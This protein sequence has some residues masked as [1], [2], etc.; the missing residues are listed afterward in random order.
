M[1]Q[2]E[3]QYS[4]YDLSRA[5]SWAHDLDVRF[6]WY[7]RLSYLQISKEIER[8]LKSFY[9]IL[10][11]NIVV[12]SLQHFISSYAQIK[13]IVTVTEL[14]FVFCLY[15]WLHNFPNVC[16]LYWL[17]LCFYFLL[18]WN[19]LPWNIFQ[20]WTNFSY[21]KIKCFGFW[22]LQCFAC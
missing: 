18:N 7:W 12:N 13:V 2:I 6:I 8:L 14:H 3:I 15:D 16:R 19:F 11:N 1:I 22:T 4:A 20:C 9:P 10:L 21:Y 5:M 17:M